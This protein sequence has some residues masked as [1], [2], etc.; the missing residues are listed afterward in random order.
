[1]QDPLSGSSSNRSWRSSAV[2]TPPKRPRRSREPLVL[3]A[4]ALL[5]AVSDDLVG[6]ARRLATSTRT[7][8]SSPS[9]TPASP[10]I[11]T[12]STPSPGTTCSTTPPGRFWP[13][14]SLTADRPHP[15]A[16]GDNNDHHQS[17]PQAQSPTDPGG[18]R[19]IRRLT[20]RSWAA[21]PRAI[22]LSVTVFEGLRTRDHRRRPPRVR[23]ELGTL[24]VASRRR[25]DQPDHGHASRRAPGHT[26][27]A[28]P[29]RPTRRRGHADRRVGVAD[30]A[31]RPCRLR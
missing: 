28:G 14:S 17:T 2:M 25:T 18:R 15:P 29:V 30:R 19:H 6:D 16:N 20:A 13:G 31:R 7:A 11:A 26:R 21:V 24:A 27:G 4:A 22:G 9:P 8:S 5:A 23:R 3:V 12:A 10:A 1:M